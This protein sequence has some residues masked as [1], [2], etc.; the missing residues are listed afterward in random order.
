MYVDYTKKHFKI[1]RECYS[2]IIET[3][4]LKKKNKMPSRGWRE[5]DELVVMSDESWVVTQ[6]GSEIVAIIAFG[7]LFVVLIVVFVLLISV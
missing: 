1:A 6:C 5:L 3:S 7:V 2:S 4:E